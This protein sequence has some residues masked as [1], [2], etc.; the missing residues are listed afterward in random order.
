MC[1]ASFVQDAR[2]KEL[3]ER[4]ARLA[5]VLNHRNIVQVFDFGYDQERA[6]LAMEYIDGVDVK[7]VIDTLMGPAWRGLLKH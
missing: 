5:A 2:F 1:I 3:F 7:G 4:E 6:W